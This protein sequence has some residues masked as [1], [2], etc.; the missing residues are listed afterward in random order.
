MGEFNINMTK[1]F[2][3]I[4]WEILPDLNKFKM[5]VLLYLFWLFLCSFFDDQDFLMAILIAGI[6]SL[7]SRSLYRKFEK[8]FHGQKRIEIS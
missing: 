1:P 3:V 2:G 7:L 4:A 6:F 5:A 8:W